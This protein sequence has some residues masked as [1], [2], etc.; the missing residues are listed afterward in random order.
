MAVYKRKGSSV[1]SYDFEHRGVRFS[2]STGEASKRKAQAVEDAKRE[3]ARIA[4]AAEAAL[5][6]P[7]LTLEQA[8]ARWWNEVGQHHKNAATTMRSLDWL[9][10]HFGK[11]KPLAQIGDAEVA[12]MVAKRRGEF[13]PNPRKKGRKYATPYVP[14]RVRPATV[15]RTATQ[16]LL[17]IL[18]RAKQIWK[19]RVQEITWRKHLLAE[20][21]ERVR[22]A[23][24]EE[25]G[26]VMGELERGYDVAVDH[27]F[28][29]GC[30][31]MEIVGLEWPRVNFFAREYTVIGKGG[32]ERTLPMTD[33]D[34]EM[35]RAELG[36]HPVHV[37]TYEAKRTVRMKG[38]RLLER[39]KRYP[40][41]DSGL[42]AAMRRA[43]GRSGVSNFH[44]HD[45]RHTAATRVLRASNLRVV[46]EL[47][48]HADIKTTV[49]YAHAL[50]DDILAA[51]EASRPKK[52]TS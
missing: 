38:G 22:V 51:L 13:V 6:S 8:C 26:S 17:F 48:G 19:A 43:I 9:M 33:A 4:T 31:R 47:L 37:F 27:A 20:P 18:H 12:W 3:E 30:R 44:F 32:R 34:Y 41:T 39:G 14:K 28:R 15:N 5:L 16:P 21:K 29:S 25:E 23:A 36:K 24:H 10:S 7:N 40:L 1:Y 42:K 45:T 11:A 52:A 35:F 2:G 46:Q 49:K 50:K